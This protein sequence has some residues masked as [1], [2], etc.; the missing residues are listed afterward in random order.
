MWPKNFSS[1]WI[2]SERKM[3]NN[4]KSFLLA[5]PYVLTKTS[6]ITKKVDLYPCIL[7]WLSEDDMIFVEMAKNFKSTKDKESLKILLE[8]INVAKSENIIS[9]MKE[10]NI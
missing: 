9:E 3:I 4:R 6:E 7:K 5:Y 10:L 1:K 2:K 8:S